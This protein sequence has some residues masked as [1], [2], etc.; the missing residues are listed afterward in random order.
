MP[1]EKDLQ[2]AISGIQAEPS[3]DC[4][5]RPAPACGLPAERGYRM[6]LGIANRASPFALR[7]AFA[8][9]AL[10]P[11]QD[12]SRHSKSCKPV[13]SALDFRYICPLFFGSESNGT[14]SNILLFKLV[15][16]N[17]TDQ[18]A[19]RGRN[20]IKSME[21]IGKPSGQIILRGGLPPRLPA[22]C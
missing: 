22:S 19:A 20:A 3:R 2:R 17:P 18:A 9:F 14:N 7:S 15:R 11:I 12:A 10:R 5:V 1:E 4:P 8:I 21:I 6:R 16:T 13:C